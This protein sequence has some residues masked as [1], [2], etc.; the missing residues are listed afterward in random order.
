MI[1]IIVN[2]IANFYYV[3]KIDKLFQVDV[4]FREQV[5]LSQN[6]EGHVHERIARD[7]GQIENIKAPMIDAFQKLSDVV[8]QYSSGHLNMVS[9][10]LIGD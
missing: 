6:F 2:V 5:E 9:L 7:V 8:I 1:W 4:E 10:R 3:K